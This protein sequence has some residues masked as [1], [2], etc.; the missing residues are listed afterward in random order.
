MKSILFFSLVAVSSFAFNGFAA[1]TPVYGPCSF[2]CESIPDE[3][4]VLRSFGKDSAPTLASSRLKILVWNLYKGRKDEFK[5]VFAKL[6]EGH[7]VIMI[8]EA[9]TADPVLTAMENV[10]GF[11][12]IFAT[13]FEMKNEVGTGTA[14]GSYATALNPGFYRTIDVEPFVN[15]PKTIAVAEYALPGTNETLLA[16]S[17]HGINWS[18]N[19]ALERQLRA[20]VADLQKHRGPVVFAGDFNI[21][22]SSRLKIA[23]KVL[24]E[25]GLTR[26]TWEN[27]ENGSQLDDAFTR[28]VMVHRARLINDYLQTASDHPAIDLD[29]EIQMR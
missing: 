9:T 29:V 1:E 16:L 8:S 27:P 28:G 7:D 11:G 18:G 26:V 21:K 15:S 13:S 5:P 3:A 25:A 12:W 23:R 4:H 20:T 22:N 6:A 14:V 17:I 2:A 24:G 19:D 10:K